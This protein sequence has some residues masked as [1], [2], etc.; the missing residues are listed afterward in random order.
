MQTMEKPAPVPVDIAA[1][2]RERYLFVCTGNTCRSPMAAALF[3]RCYANERRFAASA[4]L[5]ADGSPLSENARRALMEAGIAPPPHRSTPL[6]E[7][8]MAAATRVIGLTARHADSITWAFPAFA[9]KITA[10][11]IDIPDPYGGDLSAYIACLAKIR[12]ALA[13]MFG[14]ESEPL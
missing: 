11:P 10:L 2:K 14:P 6:T 13:E 8:Q 9:Q 3:N 7:A 1:S 12:Q 5:A 4:G